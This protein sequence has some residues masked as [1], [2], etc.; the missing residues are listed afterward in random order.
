LT[1]LYCIVATVTPSLM[2]YQK[3]T[4]ASLSD[5]KLIAENEIL[6]L[7][8][9]ILKTNWSRTRK[10]SNLSDAKKFVCVYT[11]SSQTKKIQNKGETEFT[12][13]ANQS[14]TSNCGCRVY[15]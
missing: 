9:R 8:G 2:A 10:Q 12:T 4:K 14:R 7:I 5:P 1:Q 6:N 11:Q 3:R 15:T 13:V